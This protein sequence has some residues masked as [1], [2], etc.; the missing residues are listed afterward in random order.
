MTKY[1][2]IYMN[3]G[4]NMVRDPISDPDTIISGTRKY[5]KWH[6]T[7]STLIRIYLFNIFLTQFKQFP[8]LVLQF[9]SHQ[10]KSKISGTFEYRDDSGLKT[11]EINV[12]G[13]VSIYKKGHGV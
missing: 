3:V 4:R 6:T 9:F 8:S 7:S 1:I 12:C 11:Q 10:Q 5:P 2:H 13:I